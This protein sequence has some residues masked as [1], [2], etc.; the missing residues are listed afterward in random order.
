MR[1]LGVMGVAVLYA[2]ASFLC[3]AEP[4]VST[5]RLNQPSVCGALTKEDWMKRYPEDISIEG[6]AEP[7]NGLQRTRFQ[8]ACYIKVSCGPLK[9]SVRRYLIEEENL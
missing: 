1:V 9:P 3:L 7:N 4:Q 2:V 6:E 8:R 5:Q